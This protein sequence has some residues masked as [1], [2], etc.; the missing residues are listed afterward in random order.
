MRQWLVSSLCFASWWCSHPAHAQRVDALGPEV[1]KYVRVSTPRVVLEHVEV[2]DGTG[3]P[4]SADRNILI[5]A[6][7][8]TAIS[9]GA[10][11]P[12]SDGTT[13]FDLRGY[14]G[15]SRHRRHAWAPV[16]LCAAEPWGGWQVRTP[17]PGH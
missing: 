7:T 5:E 10:D 1:R 9:P 2:V 4:P 17:R 14:S 13:V 6:G 8:I 3:A 12:A 11:M 15:D 16:V